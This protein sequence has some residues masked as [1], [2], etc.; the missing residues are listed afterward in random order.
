MS[1]SACGATARQHGPRPPSAPAGARHSSGCAR[2]PAPWPW[3]AEATSDSA[4]VP[5]R[6]RPSAPPP[7]RVPPQTVRGM[8]GLARQQKLRQPEPLE[9]ESRQPGSRQPESRQP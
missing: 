1:V 6:I 9:L 5:S 7:R 3:L 4:A 2:H 8:R